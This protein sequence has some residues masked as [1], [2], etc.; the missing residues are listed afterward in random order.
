MKYFSFSKV[1]L[2]KAF[3]LTF[4][5]AFGL[6]I[7]AGCESKVKVETKEEM[8]PSDVILQLYKALDAKDSAK[9]YALLS[10]SWRDYAKEQPTMMS[11]MIHYYDSIDAAVTILKETQDSTVANVIYRLKITG[12]DPSDTTYAAQVYRE[13]DGKWRFGTYKVIALQ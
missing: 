10:K 4:C 3:S 5:L 7:I 2:S 11:E 9:A 13:E 6:S 12:K 1:F 8:K